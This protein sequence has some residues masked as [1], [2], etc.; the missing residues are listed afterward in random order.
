MVRD[1]NRVLVTGTSR[2]SDRRRAERT[3]SGAPRLGRGR[4]QL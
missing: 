2:R 4:R 1:G 3:R